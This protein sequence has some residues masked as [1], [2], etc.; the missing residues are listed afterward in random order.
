VEGFGLSVRLKGRVTPDPVTGQLTTTFADTP[1]VPFTDFILN[2][3]GGPSAT[4]A[5][6]LACGPA[7]TSS[8]ITPYS[9]NAA[10]T[11]GSS[12]TVDLDGNGAACPPTP[13][14]LGFSAGSQNMAGGAFSPFS[15]NVT[16][17]DGQQFLSGLTV[18][19]PA[20]LLGVIQSV[21][22]CEESLAAQG[23]CPEESR[24]GTSTVTSGAGPAPFALSGP[25]Y[26]SGP[27]NGAPFGLV[28]AIRA[29]AGPF[30]LG[31]VVVRAGIKVD[32][33]D[34]HLTIDTPVLPTILQ[35]IPLRLR[36]VT[37]AID[38][39]GFLFNPTNCG[40]L[41]VAATLKSSDGATQDVSSP[42]QATGCDALPYA[43][44]M[45]ATTKA[46]KRGQP[47][48]LTV[49]L[50]QALGEANTRSVSV[51]LPS[52]L[53]ARL[54]TVGKA[55]PLAT[56]QADPT[57]CGAGSKVGTA[58]AVTSLL[59]APLSGTVYLEL[60]EPG[61]L[62]TLEAVLQGSGITVDLSGT[63]ALGNG[64]TST[65][66]AVPDV[67]ITSFRLDL[68]SGPGSVLGAG[69]DLCSAPLNFTATILGHN[70]KKADVKSVVGIAGCGVQIR[71]AKV[72]RR[73]ATLSVRAPGPGKLTLSGKG[74]GKLKKTVKA[75]GNYKIRVKLS[76][77]GVK[78]LTKARKKKSKS[79]R[80]LV[81]KVKAAYAPTK[82]MAAGGA[83]VKASSTT[84]KVTFK[85][86]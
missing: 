1:Q 52:Q 76:K 53:S 75:G 7:A 37:V 40:P 31:T 62:P 72:S 15:L 24:V 56:F 28:I 50:S 32:P 58:T 51:K 44:K 34:S 3:G 30:D 35:G 2:L 25:V 17:D 68:P 23:A 29:L 22:L 57:K 82:G 54:D 70:G 81:V 85:G 38:R 6:P 79:K 66:G 74:I 77:A 26:L 61:K 64:I 45:T 48:G 67:P 71:S 9:G 41:A 13:F 73:T 47:A 59:A 60:H 18:Q 65:F 46:A 19:Q 8:T 36:T 78:A 16:R 10:A 14:T 63:I 80:K 49:N 21:P 4:L 55:C 20:G 83:P 5:N 33:T 11:P 39:A 42:Y 84:K 12:F 86:P 27:Y 43:P 69:A